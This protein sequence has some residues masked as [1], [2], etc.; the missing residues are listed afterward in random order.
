[1]YRTYLYINLCIHIS[2]IFLGKSPRNEIAEAKEYAYFYNWVKS[3][4]VSVWKLSIYM[5]MIEVWE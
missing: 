5:P 3:A 4:K 2:I 1:M